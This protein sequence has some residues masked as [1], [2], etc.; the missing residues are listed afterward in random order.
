MNGKKHLVSSRTSSVREFEFD[1][2]EI[3]SRFGCLENGFEVFNVF[4]SEGNLHV[5]VRKEEK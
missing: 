3:L 5:E 1:I 4:F 2:E